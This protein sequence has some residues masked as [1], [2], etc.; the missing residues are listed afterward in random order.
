MQ[1]PNTTCSASRPAGSFGVDSLAIPQVNA[2]NSTGC[3]VPHKAPPLLCGA[4]LCGAMPL[5]CSAV[6]GIAIAV[7]SGTLLYSAVAALRCAE[8]HVA[9]AAPSLAWLRTA[10]PLPRCAAPRSAVAALRGASLGLAVA[11]RCW[12]LLCRCHAAH[13]RATPSPSNALPSLSGALRRIA[14]AV[15]CEA[16][17]CL[18]VAMPLP[19]LAE[20]NLAVAVLRSTQRCNA[21]AMRRASP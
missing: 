19:C 5:P 4:S 11:A 3:V 20:R 17:P 15:P 12:A 21:K 7:P 6:H 14:V 9:R 18:A 13:R 10:S 1:L 16:I 8:P 2:S